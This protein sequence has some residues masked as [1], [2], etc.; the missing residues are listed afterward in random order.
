VF[1]LVR[2]N[3]AAVGA[4]PSYVVRMP[5]DAIR[6]DEAVRAAIADHQRRT[7]WMGP[8]VLAEP[9]MSEAEWLARFGRPCT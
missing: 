7:G 6:D 5:A 9:E 3:G 8:V 1:K 4:A 2:L